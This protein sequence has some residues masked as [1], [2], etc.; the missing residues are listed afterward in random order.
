MNWK[1]SK[2]TLKGKL[3]RYGI[4]KRPL[5]IGNKIYDNKDWL[6]DQYIIQQKGYTKIAR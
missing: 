1:V 2:D 4:R 6:Y 3:R 5:K